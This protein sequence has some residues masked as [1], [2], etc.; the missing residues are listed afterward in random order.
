[1]TETQEQ[2]YVFNFGYEFKAR[3]IKLRNTP[4]KYV[5]NMLDCLK[6]V[7]AYVKDGERPPRD[8]VLAF[9]CALPYYP[10]VPSAYFRS[11][12]LRPVVSASKANALREWEPEGDAKGAE[13]LG[14][15]FVQ[16]ADN[17]KSLDI[18]VHD[19][20]NATVLS[21]HLRSPLMRGSE[22]LQRLPRY[23]LNA[24]KR[25]APLSEV[26]ALLNEDKLAE[27]A[28]R[29]FSWLNTEPF[30]LRVAKNLHAA[31]FKRFVAA[32]ES[33]PVGAS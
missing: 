7:Q 12:D 14:A 18:L 11:Y 28:Q 31:A 16:A 24:A 6:N 5:Q 15:F 8:V 3:E 10:V 1:M 29:Y 20:R 17:P 9:L 22:P 33:K 21:R 4:S 23:K 32:C 26:V 27:A 13:F 25:T 2:A 30:G 19:F